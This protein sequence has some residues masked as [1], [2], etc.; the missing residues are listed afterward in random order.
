LSVPFEDLEDA[1]ELFFHE[2]HRNVVG[3][4]IQFSFDPLL[5]KG[6]FNFKFKGLVTE[7]ALKNTSDTS[8][9]FVLKGS[10]LTV[11]LED[12]RLRRTFLQCSLTDIVNQVLTPY[13]SNLL[14]RS[15][16]PK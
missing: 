8:N 11:L 4:T 5:E 16:N 15:V 7:L 3:K 12:S 1:N 6:S 10:S 14:K 9:V 13:P 2:S